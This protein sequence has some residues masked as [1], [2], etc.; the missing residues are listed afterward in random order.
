[1]LRINKCSTAVIALIAIFMAALI[2]LGVFITRSKSS[3]ETENG[4]TT[5]GEYFVVD[6]EWNDIDFTYRIVHDKETGVKYMIIASGH[7]YGITPLYN[8]DGS[9]QNI[10][11]NATKGDD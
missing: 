3:V 6:K 2:T 1:M 4:V 7:R 9:L 10:N 5:Y 8:A 11:D